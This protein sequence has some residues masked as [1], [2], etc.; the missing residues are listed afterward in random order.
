[1]NVLYKGNFVPQYTLEDYEKI[2]EE[3]AEEFG[4]RMKTLLLAFKNR[5]K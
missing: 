4:A 3:S 5:T 1:L 2:K